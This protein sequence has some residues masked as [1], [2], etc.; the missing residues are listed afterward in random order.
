MLTPRP[1]CW[2]LLPPHRSWSVAA[3]ASAFLSSKWSEELICSIALVAFA[4]G[5]GAA[6]TQLPSTTKP[7]ERSNV[8]P[9]HATV[10]P[11]FKW[12]FLLSYA[13]DAV[14]STAWGCKKLSRSMYS[15]K[16]A[17]SRPHVLLELLR[18]GWTTNCWLSRVHDCS[19]TFCAAGIVPLACESPPDKSCL[20]SHAIGLFFCCEPRAWW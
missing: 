1:S 20:D 9:P 13:L 2:K 14:E 4:W 11:Q 15:G 6:N 3:T 17:P 10:P 16:P 19:C 12:A 8:A 7:G 18:L 5:G